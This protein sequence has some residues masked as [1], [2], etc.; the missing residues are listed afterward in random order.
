MK[1][2][3]KALSIFLS[4]L[5]ILS[6]WVWV[7]PD[8]ASASSAISGVSDIFVAV[9][10]TIYLNPTSTKNFQYY[11]NNILDSSG[12]F[13]L[14]KSNAA[15]KGKYFFK[16]A[17]ATKVTI[18]LESG[19]AS[20]TKTTLKNEAALTNGFISGEFTG[21]LTSGLSSGNTGDLKWTF[22]FTGKDG[23]AYSINAYT[24]VYSPYTNPV[25]A[26]TRARNERDVIS[27]LQSMAWI[28]GIHNAASNGGRAINTVNFDPMHGKITVP[29]KTQNDGGI[30]QDEENYHTA[31]AGTG[32][33]AS[34][35]GD[36]KETSSGAQAVSPLGSITVDKSR[37]SNF[38]QIPNF[39]IGFLISL[40]NEGEN[41]VKERGFG[42]YVSDY[43]NYSTAASGTHHNG[44]DP[45]Y[46]TDMGTKISTYTYTATGNRTDR[47]NC[48]PRLVCNAAW[49]KAVPFATGTVAIKAAAQLH[50]KGD[51]KGCSSGAT[52]N[53]YN[54]NIVGVSVSVT[55]KGALR[56]AI[57]NCIKD[58]PW[59][60]FYSSDSTVINTFKPM[61]AS[62]YKVLGNPLATQD[63]INKAKSDLDA[64]WSGV[65]VSLKVYP[66]ANVNLVD[67]VFGE[68]SGT[69]NAQIVTASRSEDGVL[70]L[71]TDAITDSFVEYPYKY[72]SKENINNGQNALPRDIID[73]GTSNMKYIY[74]PGYTFRYFNTKADNS[75]DKYYITHGENDTYSYQKG[76]ETYDLNNTNGIN[77]VNGPMNL[78]GVWEPEYCKV[79]FINP[80]GALLYDSSAEGNKPQPKDYKAYYGANGVPSYN[81]GN[82]YKFTFMGWI[83]MDNGHVVNKNDIENGLL[84]EFV[85]KDTTYMACYSTAVD[86]E[87]TYTVKFD[88]N[89]DKDF[90]DTGETQNKTQDNKSFKYYDKIYR[91]INPANVYLNGEVFSYHEWFAWIDTMNSDAFKDN[92]ISIAA[93]EQVETNVAYTFANGG[94]YVCEIKFADGAGPVTVSFPGLS[95][96]NVSFTADGSAEFTSGGTSS[97][98]RISSTTPVKISELNVYRK[99]G[100]KR[101]PSG[102]ETLPVGNETIDTLRYDYKD[103]VWVT[104]SGQK[105]TKNSRLTTDGQSYLISYTKY[106]VNYL[107]K[108]VSKKTDSD[109]ETRTFGTGS[110]ALY[111]AQKD[112][113]EAN[114]YNYTYQYDGDK[115]FPAGESYFVGESEY[116]FQYWTDKKDN[117]GVHHDPGDP[118]DE[119]VRADAGG[120]VYYAVYKLKVAEYS[121]QFK[122]DALVDGEVKS[123]V[124]EF[125]AP[126]GG[127]AN[128]VVPG[129]V[130]QSKETKDY[131]YEFVGWNNTLDDEEPIVGDDIATIPSKYASITKNAVY[132]AEYKATPYYYLS[133]YDFNKAFVGKMR[134][135]ENAP[136]EPVSTEIETEALKSVPN[137]D[138]D[139]VYTYE[140]A[141][142]ETESHEDLVIGEGITVNRDTPT[143]YFLKVSKGLKKYP[144]T[145]ITAQGT[146]TQSVEYG[147]SPV[148]TGINKTKAPNDDYEYRFDGWDDDSTDIVE[149]YSDDEIADYKVS[150][151][152]SFT[153]VYDESTRTYAVV[154]KDIDTVTYNPVTDELAHDGNYTD[155]QWTDFDVNYGVNGKYPKYF[156]GERISAPVV[157]P[158]HT[159]FVADANHKVRFDGW[160]PSK[161][162]NANEKLTRTTFAEKDLLNGDEEMVFYAHYVA[163]PIDMTVTFYENNETATPLYAAGIAYGA[164]AEDAANTAANMLTAD[165]DGKVGQ[166]KSFDHWAV[167]GTETETEADLANVTGDM[168]VYAVYDYSDHEWK[169]GTTDGWEIIKEATYSEAGERTR[170]CTVCG[171]RD[172]EYIT[173]LKDKEDPTGQIVIKNNV[174]DTENVALTD[175]VLYADEFDAKTV[176]V[177]GKTVDVMINGRDT[178][179]GVGSVKYFVTEAPLTEAALADY[180]WN[181]AKSTTA[182]NAHFVQKASDLKGASFIV[183]AKIDDMAKDWEDD[184][185]IVNGVPKTM[186]DNIHT[187]YV[188][189]VKVVFDNDIPEIVVNGDAHN[190]DGT[191]FC[192]S[193]TVTVTDE[194]LDLVTY[195]KDGGAQQTVDLSEGAQTIN[196]PG[197]YNVFAQDKGGNEAEFAFTVKEGHDFKFTQTVAPNCTEDG[198]D[199]YTCSVCGETE[200][201]NTVLAL[202]HTYPMVDDVAVKTVIKKATCEADGEKAFR[203]TVCGDISEKETIAACEHKYSEIPDANSVPATCSKE[204]VNYFTCTCEETDEYEACTYVNVVNLGKLPHELAFVEEVPATCTEDG[205]TLNR[206][207]NCGEEERIPHSETATGH[208]YT[209]WSVSYPETCKAYGLKKRVCE[210]CGCEEYSTIARHDPTYE[211]SYIKE[212]TC[213]ASGTYKNVC[214]KCG[215]VECNADGKEIIH[216]EDALGHAYE[217]ITVEPTCTEAGYTCTECSRCGDTTEHTN[218]VD[219]LG[220]DW[221]PKETVDA[222]YTESGWKVYECSRCHEEKR[223]Q[224]PPLAE[225]K[226]NFYSDGELFGAIGV[227]AASIAVTAIDFDEPEKTGYEFTKWVY[228]D[229]TELGE[230]ITFTDETKVYD[231][232]AVFTPK[233]YTV[234]WKDGNKTETLAYD[235]VINEYFPEGDNIPVK[236]RTDT[237]RYEF[238]G[239][240]LTENGEKITAFSAVTVTGEMTF[241]PVFDEFPLEFTIKFVDWNGNVVEEQTNV[242]Y[243][244]E[245]VAPTLETAKITVGDKTVLL[246]DY[247]DTTDPNK[248]LKWSGKWEPMVEPATMDVTYTAIYNV[249]PKVV[250]ISFY[251]DEADAEPYRIAVYNAGD[252]FILPTEGPAKEADDKYTYS[253]LGWLPKADQTATDPVDGQALVPESNGYA[254]VADYKETPIEYTVTFANEDEEAEPY[255]EKTVY[256]NSYINFAPD[257]NSMVKDVD[258]PEEEGQYVYEFKGWSYKGMTY[259]KADLANMQVKGN[260]VLTPV[261]EKVYTKIAV[262][263]AK[264]DGGYY[265]EREFVYNNDISYSGATPLKT[266]D[267]QYSYKFLGWNTNKNATEAIELGKATEAVTFYPVFEPVLRKYDITWVV[268]NKKFTQSVEAGAEV[269]Y[270]ATAEGAPSIDGDTYNTPIYSYEFKGWALT[271]D[272][273]ILDAIPEATAKATYYAIFDK[274]KSK[275]TAKWFLNEGDETPLYEKTFDYATAMVYG[276]ETPVKTPAAEDASKLEY[277]FKGWVDQDGNEIAADAANC[278]KIT[279]NTVFTAV[280]ETSY[281]EFT[282]TF[283]GADNTTVYSTKTDYHYGDALVVPAELENYDSEDGLTANTFIG[284]A[285]TA[286]ATEALDLTDYT[287]T[288]NVSFYPVYSTEEIKYATVTF[289]DD[290]DATIS[291]KNYRV[292]EAVVVP[293]DPKKEATNELVYTFKGWAK[294]DDLETILEVIPAAAEDVTY[295]A[296]FESAYR[297]Y[298]ATFYTDEGK[299]ISFSTGTHDGLYLYNE[300]ANAPVATKA[301]TAMKKYVFAGWAEKKNAAVEDVIYAPTDIITVTAD[302]NLYAVFTEEAKTYTVTFV[303][304]DGSEIIPYTDQDYNAQIEVPAAP[305]KENTAEYTYTFDGWYNGKAKLVTVKKDGKEYATVTSDVTY[306]ATFKAEATLYNVYFYNVDKNLEMIEKAYA[307]FTVGYG[308]AFPTVTEPADYDTDSYNYEFK[309]WDD[310]ATDDVEHL[311]ADDLPATVTKNESFKA[312]FTKTERLYTVKFL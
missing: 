99:D 210:T 251:L 269:A 67:S 144:V 127:D 304:E 143:A 180:A 145:F 69:V 256:Y 6:C 154:F 207:E 197:I 272:G 278:G 277:I 274:T 86:D 87:K 262:K 311:A 128:V 177:K 111:I 103:P 294:V 302:I 16:C 211:K 100:Y 253:F 216:T 116:E 89:L 136:L 280:F 282:A 22:T 147:S 58:F 131:L 164:S 297:T 80:D 298:R 260:M 307:N 275:Y 235:S 55:D 56:N 46:G 43:S 175:G 54:S 257:D 192:V 312:V 252:T 217:P 62:A 13:S 195:S 193:A 35:S 125:T 289:V 98:I 208:T 115:T 245:I 23:R 292:G 204:G 231:L 166:H 157:I 17:D 1:N 233:N 73:S 123:V 12:N 227:Q 167:K 299:V 142:W 305:P 187:T 248:T 214:S 120:R 114:I 65:Y 288:E 281:F 296:V 8:K 97:K 169:S 102:I 254:Y 113:V 308:S 82:S 76:S 152:A 68:P 226:I 42:Y 32:N 137:N 183:Y 20:F 153:A 139:V 261:F 206:C 241:Y 26:A 138:D 121:V 129:D 146:Y 173:I 108:F 246:K 174:S 70:S 30:T 199:L 33:L 59:T 31:A 172:D 194:Y 263:F 300:T 133:F 219:A 168:N 53:S 110:D 191:V 10:E 78:Y 24:T 119:N 163:D 49:D 77:N 238:I 93:D 258:K 21:S 185:E 105:L 135:L 178:G 224:I 221:Q 4:V 52:D 267:W 92:E 79:R 160:Y 295:K 27:D 188:T 301:E 229:D 290:N 141:G 255:K 276:G 190:E 242:P 181:E 202:G 285:I 81:A 75:G 239:W 84:S 203:C 61:L 213:T 271:A 40:V 306:K 5:M 232:K 293:A 234:T 273:E 259:K 158:D 14:E 222:T 19:S 212:P 3:K 162:F 85:N 34:I 209:E 109:D 225:N 122:Y 287:V 309:G 95:G 161:E 104:A 230:T 148:L 64:A 286:D 29:D 15:D 264:L 66:Q 156:L 303:G 159:D 83:N 90:D 205:Y 96:A 106:P 94:V 189:S 237:Y 218:N 132:E 150:G 44:N 48:R 91:V 41:G 176:Y 198:Y 72:V 45:Y 149:R 165:D 249:I 9:P 247:E 117:T 37:Y 101:I 7:A 223:D 126:Y 88:I 124:K 140:I 196:D 155:Y 39:K 265:A 118:L 186:T 57:N 236:E 291:T 250:N 182:R 107:A 36:S 243:G 112:N 134:Y 25:F 71:G 201:R 51:G 11:V 179:T 200:K 130:I 170:Y 151:D 284:W 184:V 240:S 2:V 63:Q 270:P 244:T 279:K 310:L 283:Y 268:M 228:A 18:T 266:R 60:G 28:Q 171:H 47:T 38:N 215:L 220:H 74:K 50:L